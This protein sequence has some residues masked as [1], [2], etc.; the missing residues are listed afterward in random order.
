MMFV[1]KLAETMRSPTLV[2]LEVFLLSPPTP[3]C[4]NMRW[5][6]NKE[7]RSDS[8]YVPRLAAVH[9]PN[10]A[11]ERPVAGMGAGRLS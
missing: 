4:A 7:M 11:R 3:A 5:V 8:L 1:A 10:D 2:A 6:G 9:C